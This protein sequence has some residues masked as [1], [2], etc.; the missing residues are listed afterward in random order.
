MN[1]FDKT[2]NL[3]IEDILKNS[4]LKVE[5]PDVRRIKKHCLKK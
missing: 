5:M 2:Y 3:I 1:K 4:K